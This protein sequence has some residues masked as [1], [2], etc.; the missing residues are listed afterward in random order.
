[1]YIA[2]E[3]LDAAVLLQSTSLGLA[4]NT[5]YLLPSPRGTHRTHELGQTSPRWVSVGARVCITRFNFVVPLPSLGTVSYQIS[6]LVVT[7][8]NIRVVIYLPWYP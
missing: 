7:P 4:F 1:M 3:I 8:T 5:C 2:L 6:Y